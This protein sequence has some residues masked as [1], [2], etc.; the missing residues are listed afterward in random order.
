[1]IRRPALYDEN[2]VRKLTYDNL[3]TDQS[4]NI[5]EEADELN[6]TSIIDE[7]ITDLRNIAHHQTVY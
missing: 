2:V 7:N 1:M 5:Q 3:T 6:I 4:E